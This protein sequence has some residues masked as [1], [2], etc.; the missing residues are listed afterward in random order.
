MNLIC[1]QNN[2]KV[3]NDWIML[4]SNLNTYQCK[5]SK[6]K[7]KRKIHHI[8]NNTWDTYKNIG[9]SI[10]IRLHTRWFNNIDNI[11]TNSRGEL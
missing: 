5:T 7:L 10:T 1:F 8:Y 4:Y 9:Y 3:Y 11:L 6:T 2:S